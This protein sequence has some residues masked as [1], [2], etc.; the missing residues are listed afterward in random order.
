MNE[1]E[2]LYLFSRLYELQRCAFG[3]WPEISAHLREDD[4]PVPIAWLRRP[5]LLSEIRN[6]FD[7]ARNKIMAEEGDMLRPFMA[8]PYGERR[9]DIIRLY[10]IED[11]ALIIEQLQNLK[12]NITILLDALNSKKESNPT[13]VAKTTQC[14][15]ELIN[16]ANYING[17]LISEPI[18][19]DI[20]NML[21][22]IERQVTDYYSSLDHQS[23]NEEQ[24]LAQNEI[25][26]YYVF[27]RGIQ[28]LYPELID[29][30][31]T[32][33]PERFLRGED[34]D[35]VH[36]CEVG[37]PEDILDSFDRDFELLEEII[38]HDDT[39]IGRHLGLIEQELI[40]S[41]TYNH[42][43]WLKDRFDNKMITSQF[44]YSFELTGCPRLTR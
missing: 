41:D 10:F 2:K 30:E 25:Y 12:I 34:E 40:I 22:E 37:S 19:T 1:R 11:S 42:G 9:D 3:N 18:F 31:R 17:A 32:Q 16:I 33:H 6:V 27:K 15:L 39:F 5:E 24:V 23:I 38:Q 14:I 20:Q 7:I 26:S 13:E 28:Q 43:L 29:W 36:S 35:S 44:M 4:L 21:V 8:R